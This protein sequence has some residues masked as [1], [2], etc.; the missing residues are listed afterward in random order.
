MDIPVL[1]WFVVGLGTLIIGAQMLVRGASRLAAAL[2]LSPLV[3]G[4]TVVT[5]GTTSPELAVTLH[6]ALGGQADIA[7]G[8]IIGSNIFNILFIL[9]LSALLLPLAVSS[10]V[11]RLEVPIM[12]GASVLLFLLSLDGRLEPLDGGLLLASLTGYTAFALRQSRREPAA[13]EAAYGEK[14][15]GGRGPTRGAGLLIPVGSVLMGVLL[16]VFGARWLL[17]GAVAFARA[18]GVSEL[19]IGLTIVAAGTS[20]PEV[21]TAIVATVRGEREIAVGNIIGSCIYNVMAILG[22][23]SLLAPGG[24]PVAPAALSFDIPVMIGAAVA[25]L[26]IFFTGHRIARW[27]GGLFLGYYT[28]YALYLILAAL[29]HDAL[30]TFSATMLAFVIPLTVITLAVLAVRAAERVG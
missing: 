15:G 27:E 17:H 3:I 16:L 21:A 19:I 9:G 14:Y 30:S 11:V 29:E 5:Y 10:R 8:N 7:L 6:A 4:L 13:I 12:I 23:A 2:G 18:I 1:A 25:C 26:P 24:V 28:A 22:L 20:M